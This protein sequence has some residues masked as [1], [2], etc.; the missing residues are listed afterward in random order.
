MLYVARHV[1]WVRYYQPFALHSSLISQLP[2]KKRE[3]DEE[4]ERTC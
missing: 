3:G 4:T 1:L 2:S